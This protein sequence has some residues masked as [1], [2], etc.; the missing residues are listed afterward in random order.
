M[1]RSGAL[2]VRHQRRVPSAR[3]LDPGGAQRAVAL[4]AARHCALV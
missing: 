4:T 1:N 2:S 3:T